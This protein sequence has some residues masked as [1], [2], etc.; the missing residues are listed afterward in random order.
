MKKLFLTLAMLLLIVT[1][2]FGQIAFGTW[3]KEN[4][5]WRTTTTTSQLTT[6]TGKDTTNTFQM[7]SIDSDINL[8]NVENVYMTT[9]F[10]SADADSCAINVTLQGGYTDAWDG[11]I[12]T[13]VDGPDTGTTANNGVN[14]IQFTISTVDLSYPFWRIIYQAA[15]DHTLEANVTTLYWFVFVDW[16]K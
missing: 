8:K 12:W 6:A 11:A 7:K 4:D 10:R 3:N 13:T 14:E 9:W 16:D 2:S 5:G 15:T 1:V